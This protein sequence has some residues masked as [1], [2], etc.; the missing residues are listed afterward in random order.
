MKKASIRCLWRC[1][2]AMGL[3]ACH[4]DNNN[5]PVITIDQ[6]NHTVAGSYIQI[7]GNYAYALVP[8]PGLYNF[9]IPKG[10]SDTIDCTRLDTAVTFNFPAS[11]SY[12]FVQSQL[13]GYVDTTNINSSMWLY[14]YYVNPLWTLPD[15]EYPPT[16][17]QKYALQ[18][19]WTSTNKETVNTYNYSGMV[20]SNL[21]LPDPN[22]YNVG[23]NQVSNFSVSFT[24]TKPTYYYTQWQNT[25]VTWTLYASPDSASLQPFE[26]ANR[27]KKQAAPGAK[28]ELAYAK[29]LSIRE[30]AGLR[31]CRLPRAYL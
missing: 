20:P 11:P 9:H 14:A 28:P 21:A 18:T 16:L 25:A 22:A 23:S 8:I 4:K 1:T 3:I 7:P 30:R 12:T 19:T 27:A 17:I 6:L 5:P 10:V 29:N 26:P 24:G 31:L 2:L 15:L 13:Y